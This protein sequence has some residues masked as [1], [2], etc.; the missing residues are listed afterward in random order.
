MTV[1]RRLRLPTMT[2]NLLLALILVTG[3]IGIAA[4]VQVSLLTANQV[5]DRAV[6]RSTNESLCAILRLFIPGPGD[7]PST[8]ERGRK[9]ITTFRRQY[10]DV[11]KCPNPL[12]GPTPTISP[13]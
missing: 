8:T 11:L 1:L 10:E 4:L 2:P 5:E 9:L 12:S 7:P 13:R 6:S 3:L